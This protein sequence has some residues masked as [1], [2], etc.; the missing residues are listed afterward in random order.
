MNNDIEMAIKRIESLEKRME[1]YFEL[2]DLKDELEFIMKGIYVT[3]DDI[4][5]VL[6]GNY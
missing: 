1:L 5:D 6:L 2:L 3:E 4:E